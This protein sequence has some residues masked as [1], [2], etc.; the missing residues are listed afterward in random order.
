[1]KIAVQLTLL[2]F[3][4]FLSTPTI[5]SAIE[6]SSDTSIFF[7]VAEEELSHKVVTTKLEVHEYEFVDLSGF[8]SKRIASQEFL[9]HKNVFISIV[10]PPPD[11]A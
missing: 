3:T 5:V 8:L 7:N 2:M 1:M 11:M 4:L 9:L 6:K 10:I